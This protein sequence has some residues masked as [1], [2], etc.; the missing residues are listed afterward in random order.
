ML[1]HVISLVR[2][3][4]LVCVRSQGIVSD[5]S[6]SGGLVRRKLVVSGGIHIGLKGHFNGTGV[7]ML[8]WLYHT[9]PVRTDLYLLI[10]GITVPAQVLL[11]SLA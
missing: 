7:S 5:N 2:N 6:G 9:E 1:Y 8:T 11:T 10:C 4:G 3:T